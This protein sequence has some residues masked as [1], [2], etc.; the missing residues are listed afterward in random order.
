MAI[1]AVEQGRSRSE[2][3][4]MLG[5]TH[6]SVSKWITRY[7]AGGID[8]LLARPLGRP[9]VDHESR[10]ASEMRQVLLSQL[11]DQAGLNGWLWTWRSVQ[12]LMFRHLGIEFSRWTIYRYMKDWGVQQP[13]SPPVTTARP[14]HRKLYA[15]ACTPLELRLSERQ[16]YDTNSRS[17]IW[18]TS[19][20]GEAAFMACKEP[21]QEVVV[22]FLHR[23]LLH[24]GD[25]PL[26][27]RG[28][29][30]LVDSARVRDW[31][32]QRSDRI[33]IRANLQ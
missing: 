2:V 12:T 10:E 29:P 27:V 17:I 28:E 20:R 9:P 21:S 31:A 19:G 18:A 6:T 22:E 8:D 7:R 1:R 11:P 5:T 33:V 14:A 26:A 4:A 23:L 24:D 30:A 32:L 3:A 16:T 13:A 25:R 15:L